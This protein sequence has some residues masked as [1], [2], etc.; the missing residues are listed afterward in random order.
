MVEE[1]PQADVGEHR[2]LRVALDAL[3]GLVSVEPDEAEEVLER[4][5]AHAVPRRRPTA[6]TSDRES[7]ASAARKAEPASR[8]EP[9]ADGADRETSCGRD[10][11]CEDEPEHACGERE[12][13]QARR[14]Q[15]PPARRSPRRRRSSASA[16]SAARSWWPRKDEWRQPDVQTAKTSAPKN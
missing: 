8:R 5:A 2:S 13:E 9:E 3:R 11:P 7:Q 14:R 15:L 1:D 16:E 4:V 12:R 10:R 6:T